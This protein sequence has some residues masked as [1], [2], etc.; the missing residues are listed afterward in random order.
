MAPEVILGK[1]YDETA[2]IFS[3]GMLL[4]EIITRKDVGKL[5]PRAVQDQFQI[6]DNKLRPQIPR[7]S[8]KHFV[9]LAF[10]CTKYDPK[11]RPPFTRIILFLKK[12]LKILVDAKKTGTDANVASAALDQI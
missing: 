6:N 11:K 9:E 4:F 12:L 8:P 2:D 10:L 1:E 3:F 7:D 5:I